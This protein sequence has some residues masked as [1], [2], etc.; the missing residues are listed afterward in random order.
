LTWELGSTAVVV[1]ALAAGLA[2]YE[3]GRP[4][5]KLVAL[6]AALAALAIAGRVLFTPIPNVQATTDI[7]LLSGYALGPVPGFVVGSIAALT[8]NFL[9]GQGPW[10]PWQMFGWGMAGVAGGVLAMLFGRR[11]GRW[12]LAFA[13]AAAGFVFGAWMDLFTLL[14]FAAERSTGSYLAVAGV[15]LPFNVAHAAGNAVLCLAFGPGFVRMLARFRRRL[16]VRWVRAEEAAAGAGVLLLLLC[17]PLVS[18]QPARAEPG[19]HALRYLERAQNRDG[20][21][22]GAP[23][24]SSSQLIT[25]WAVL[26]LEA[27]GRNPL[28]ER[29]GGGTPIDF[30]RANARQLNDTGELERTI[31]ALRGAGLDPRKFAGRDLVA[32]LLHRRRADGSFEGL[33]NLTAFAVLALRSAG[34]SASSV[35]VAAALRWLAAHQNDDGGF[36][37][38]GKGV[39][40]VDETG[41]ALQALAASEKRSGR[42]VRRTIA[43][44]RRAQADDGGYGQ[45]KGYRSNAQSTAWAVQGIVAAGKN[46]SAFKRNGSSSPVAYLASLQQGDGSYR[47]SRSSAQTPVWVTAQVIAA[48]GRKPFPIRPVKRAAG[49][50]A[51]RAGAAHASKAIGRHRARA[52][53]T[54]RP[55]RPGERAPKRAVALRSAGAAT[56]AAAPPTG[57]KGDS[58]GSPSPLVFILLPV[59]AIAAGWWLGRRRAR[60]RDR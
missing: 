37:T 39:S 14:S 47:Y 11:L 56:A 42:A 9:L 24:E 57:A 34:R 10:T 3:R 17:V 58:G 38:S 35:P 36:S 44:L 16:E 29:R 53:A 27:A 19:S 49:R 41:A 25:G 30:A 23:G 48:L 20:G 50:R 52:R 51:P 45:S 59:A 60:R 28:D 12:P 22:G 55:A 40:F 6:I 32:E 46:P 21:F 1:L 31:L 54:V 26:G 15:S 7:V 4:S 2:W 43:F 18:T 13:C 33:S 8:S 5:S